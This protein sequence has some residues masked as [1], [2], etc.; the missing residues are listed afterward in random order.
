M[1][2]GLASEVINRLA[3]RGK[4]KVLARASSFAFAGFALPLPQIAEP[5]GVHHVLTGMLCR[6][7][8]TL[9]LS[10]ELFDAQGFIVWSD[11]YQQAVNPSGK[12]TRTLA[13]AV[14]GGVAAKLGDLL[15][16]TPDALVDKLIPEHRVL[17]GMLRVKEG[18]VPV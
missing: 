18:A 2:A 6:D 12:I 13:S 9:T 1:A 17:G 15:P 10:A 8:N 3:E 5:L 7:G 16:A 4:L 11:S 14:A